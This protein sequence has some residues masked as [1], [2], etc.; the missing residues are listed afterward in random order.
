M[1]LTEGMAVTE[2][3]GHGGLDRVMTREE[4][5]DW[6]EGFRDELTGREFRE[7]REAVERAEFREPKEWTDYRRRY[8]ETGS[9]WLD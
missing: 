5:L 9:P 7:C 8:A 1:M 3:L 4:W 6:L 2:R